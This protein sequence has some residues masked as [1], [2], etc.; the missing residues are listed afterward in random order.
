MHQTFMLGNQ[1]CH[2]PSIDCMSIY[3]RAGVHYTLAIAVKKF[4]HK[5]ILIINRFVAPSLYHTIFI[6]VSFSP[7]RFLK[8]SGYVSSIPFRSQ[9]RINDLPE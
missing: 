2:Y 1:I 8:N 5:T 9:H 4:Y 7:V 6:H 3:G